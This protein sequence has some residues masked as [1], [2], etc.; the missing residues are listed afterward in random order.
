MPSRNQLHWYKLDKKLSGDFYLKIS[1]C[2]VYQEI[3]D[4][5]IGNIEHT[6]QVRIVT[7]QRI[8]NLI[9]ICNK[10]ISY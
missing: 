3:L 4:Q 9:L 6:W 10:G 5:A 2:D 8:W 1:Q 7:K